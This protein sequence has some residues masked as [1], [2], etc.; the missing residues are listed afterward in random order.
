ML[1]RGNKLQINKQKKWKVDGG[2][3]GG[4]LGV[5]RG[6]AMGLDVGLKDGEGLGFI[7]MLGEG[8]PGPGS[9][10]GEC[11]ITKTGEFCCVGGEETG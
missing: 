10:P 2:A 1:Y 8:V 11:S 6:E 7:G 5:G 4:C 3:W 9:C